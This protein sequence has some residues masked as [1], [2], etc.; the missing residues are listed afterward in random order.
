MEIDPKTPDEPLNILTNTSMYANQNSSTFLQQNNNTSSNNDKGKQNIM[1]SN[2]DIYE[3]TPSNSNSDSNGNRDFKP[4]YIDTICNNTS[5]TETKNLEQ[6]FKTLSDDL[7]ATK[8][9]SKELQQGQ[10]NLFMRVENIEQL[11]H[12]SPPD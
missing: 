8:N 11:C 6:K 4:S 1:W 12:I 5:Q 10:L 2:E 7:I 9:I 3:Q